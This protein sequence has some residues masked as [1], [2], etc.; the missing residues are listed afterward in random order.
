MRKTL[1]ILAIICVLFA[2]AAAD[3]PLS[4]SAQSFDQAGIPAQVPDIKPQPNGNPSGIHVDFGNLPLYFTANRGQVDGRALFYARAARFTLWLTEEGLVF[5]SFKSERPEAPSVGKGPSLRP[6]KRESRGYARDVSRLVFLNAAKH[7]EIV[8]LDETALK[9]NYF[10][11]NDPAKWHTAVP[12]SGAVLYKNIYDRIDLKVYGSESRIEYDWIVRPG[13]NPRDIRFE[14]RNVK[15]TRVDEAGNLLIETGFGELVHKKPAAYQEAGGKF[16]LSGNGTRV[17]VESAFKKIT[18]NAYGFEVGTYEAGLELV[19]DPV[20]DQTAA[21][22][23]FP[24]YSTYLGGSG[25][26]YG[27]GIAVDGSG[28]AYVTGYTLSADFPTLNQYQTDQTG[29]DVF[30]TKIDTAKSGNASL[31]YSTYLGGND[32][33]IGNGIAVDSGG[34]AYVTGFTWST[35]F[36]T[37]NQ[38]QTNQAGVDVFVTKIDTTKSGNA[39]LVYSTYLG[40]NQADEGY[41]IAVDGS[42]NA[43]VSGYSYS[44]NFPTLNQYQT[45]QGGQDVFITK[46]DTTKSGNASLI[47]STYLG[48]GSDDFGRGIAVDVSG[49]AYVTGYTDSAD[50]PTLNQ[51]QTDQAGRD[52][53]VT[54]IDTTKSGNASLVYSTYLGG[55]DDDYGIGIAVDNSGN[56]YVTG[57]PYSTDFPTLNQYQTYLGDSNSNVFVTKLDTTKSGNASLVYSTYLGGNNIDIGYGIAVD[58]SGNAYVTGWTSSTNFPLLGWYQ[59]YPGDGNL[60]AFVTKLDTTKSGN[61]SLV[62]STYLGGNSQDQGFGIAVDGSGNAYVTGFTWSTDFPTVNQYQTDQPGGDAFITKIRPSTDIAIT[63][64]SDNL[65]PKVGETFNFTVTAK[66]SPSMGASGLKVTDL[67]PAGL[68]FVSSTASKG[69][70][71]S[72]TGIWD[73]GALGKGETATLTLGVTGTSAGVVTNTASVSALNEYDVI[74][75]NNTASATVAVKN[76]LT[77]V[78]GA[79]GTTNP[80]PGT[81]LYDEGA[82]V[83]ISATAAA[84]YRFGSWSGDATGSTNPVSV[85]MNGN[86]TVTANFIRQYTLIIAAGS[87]GT[88]SPVPGTYTYDEGTSVSIQATAATGYRFLGWSGDASGTANPTAITMNGDKTVTANFM[89]QYTLTIAAGAGGTTSPVPG[90]Y[91]YDEGISVSVQATASAGSRFGNWTGDASGSANPITVT[92]NGNKTVTANFIRQFTLTIIAGANG[93]TSPVPGIYT[94]DEGTSVSVQ[95]TAS[96]G[97]RFGSWSG[98]ATGSTNPITITMNGNKTVTANFVRRY[99]LTITAGA[100]GTTSPVPGIYTY[101][102]GTSVSVQAVPAA[103]YQ[104][105]TWTGDASGSANLVTVV[106]NGNKAVQA[107]FTRVVKPTLSLTGERLQNR[108]VSMVENVIRLR[109]QPNTANTGT[110]SYRIYQIENGQATAIANV[111]AGTYEYIVRRVLTT[112]T[113]LFG[114][115][116]VNSQGWE[117]DMVQIAVQ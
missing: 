96:A 77:I 63:K 62:Y 86:K 90:T 70:Y 84:G 94:Y 14:Y 47:Y 35:N 4:S 24:A 72:G 66:N 82:S 37:L 39:S 17:A 54:K 93:T 58:G 43:Y 7:P 6:E 38:Y 29:T 116:A 81:Y 68:T 115:T 64:T 69:T 60:N 27:Q 25:N 44:A 110:I 49:N 59:I 48:G 97:Y 57:F 113:Y 5:D 88:T 91:I 79:G 75:A 15:G 107:N 74:P 112:R 9:V 26:D 100:N 101:D 16:G 95:A 53:F 45:V 36:P 78:A 33:D 92:M 11:G 71:T 102:E 89:R 3:R 2:T 32:E 31:V 34:N 65:T 117:S 19:I 87:G 98:D 1:F 73:I 50:F 28:N 67:L 56:A 10:I 114:V 99:T 22:N 55:N 109:W 104:L 111:G 103:A 18:D 85:T 23:V 105:D 21:Y 30:V 108:N 80:V 52:V 83:S 41:G 12:T 42:G 61:A 20:I 40:G 13:G 106:M 46:I 8:P 76:T 51:Y